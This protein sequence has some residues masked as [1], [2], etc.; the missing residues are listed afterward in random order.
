MGPSVAHLPTNKALLLLQLALD[1]DI[2]PKHTYIQSRDE[3][4]NCSVAVK[5]RDRAHE[6]SPP[7][8]YFTSMSRTRHE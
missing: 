6:R 3:E 1:E 5:K 2:L 4:A 7:R 8:P